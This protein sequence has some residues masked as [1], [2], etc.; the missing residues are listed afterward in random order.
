MTAMIRPYSPLPVPP[1]ATSQSIIA[2][3]ST[4][5]PTLERLS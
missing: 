1:G 5:P 2:D 4:P 3:S